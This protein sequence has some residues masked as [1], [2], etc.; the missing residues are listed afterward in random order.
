MGL[1]R[2]SIRARLTAAFSAAM[3]A[4]LTGA[5]AFV[6]LRLRADLDDRV[7][8]Q[9]R[10]RAVA[11]VDGRRD[12]RLQ[13]VA[14]E[15]PEE[16]FVQVL[17][18][19]GLV[20]QRV[21]AAEVTALAPADLALARAGE[22]WAEGAVPGIDGRVRML[23]TPWPD[24]S[25][26]AV[27]VVGQ[28]LLDRNEALSNVAGSFVIGGVAATGLASAIGYLLARA[29]LAPVEAIR[30]RAL[31]VSLS[32]DDGGLPLP[33]SRDE[34]Y[35]LGQTLNQMLE[36]L[37]RAYDREGRFVADASHELRTPITV[38]KTELEGAIRSGQY[39]PQVR[40]SLLAAQE[41]CDRLGQLAE[42]LLVLAR[43]GEGGL[44]VRPEP[45]P[46]GALLES[47]RNRFVDRAAERGRVILVEL[48]RDRRLLVDPERVRQALANLVDNAL[49]H[50][51]GEVVIGC[52]S[53]GPGI[54]LEVRDQGPGFA[55]EIAARAFERF[56]R[57]D[58][59]RTGGG[60][61]LGLAIVQAVAQ[62]HGGT[63]SI[64][65]GSGARVQ[66]ELP[67]ATGSSHRRLSRTS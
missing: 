4:M 21:G 37:R 2:A 45:V 48:D 50:G 53:A 27:I 60:S 25:G 24:P 47:V 39:G 63:V 19:D 16:S 59:A 41:E 5:A 10:A 13:G 54:R 35:R 65:P 38:I 23:A 40:E 8:A 12:G 44:P 20:R 64:G 9:L 32:R 31:Q 56:S 42:D 14:L 18:A 15:D 36:R 49:R 7:A 26:A 33:R 34:V 66:L 57:G 46:A 52:C 51:A 30:R 58:A 29:G 22:V 1:R 55:P 67:G 28:S 61:G 6:Y 3:L 43:A 62:A 17:G 11:A